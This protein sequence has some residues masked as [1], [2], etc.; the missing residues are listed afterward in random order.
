MSKLNENSYS[1]HIRSRKRSFKK[2][3]KEI[4]LKAAILFE[5]DCEDLTQQQ[6]EAMEKIDA[7]AS[8]ISLNLLPTKSKEKYLKSF[9][10]FQNWKKKKDLNENCFSE[11]VLLVYFDDLASMLFDVDV[12]CRLIFLLENLLQ[13]RTSRALYGRTTRCYDRLS[14]AIIT[15]TWPTIKS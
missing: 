15:L 5:E 8:V 6:R 12:S 7:D 4:E 2:M 9:E 3:E 10:K 1:A 11:S 14:R 13:L